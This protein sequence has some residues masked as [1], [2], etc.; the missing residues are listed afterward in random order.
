MSTVSVRAYIGLGSNL[1]NPVDQL[2]RALTELTALPHTTLVVRSPLYRTPPLG[3]A[4]QPDYINAV[5]ALDTGLEPLALLDELQRIEQAHHRER[6]VR[7]G[8]RTLDL[9]L[10]LYGTAVIEL[11][12]LTV[13]HAEMRNR[14][15]VIFPLLAIAPEL[16]LPD[17]T[18]LTELAARLAGEEPKPLEGMEGCP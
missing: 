2:C 16:I 6:T 15:F 18:P 13:P 17:G 5:A 3:P 4:G 9:D 14:P 11:P 10:L 8:A 7:W 1:D 12:R